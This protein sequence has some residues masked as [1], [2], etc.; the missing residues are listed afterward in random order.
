MME[1]LDV[2]DSEERR[3]QKGS[4]ESLK[5]LMMS[6]DNLFRAICLLVGDRGCEART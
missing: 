3:R 5:S 4:W 2:V 6:S 1:G